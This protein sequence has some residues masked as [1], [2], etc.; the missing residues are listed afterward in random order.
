MSKIEPELKNI[1]PI[2]QLALLYKQSFVAFAATVAVLIYILFWIYDLVD[3]YSL[4]LWTGAIVALNIYLLTWVYFVRRATINTRIS[5]KKAKRFIL[6]YQVQ[7]VLHGSA[8]GALPFLLIELTSP[9]MKFFS[10]IILCGMAAGAIGTTAMIYHIYLSFMLPMMLPVI[11]TQLFL[12]N[13]FIFFSR[14]ILEMLII[15]VISLLVL[16]H[17]HFE[18]IKRS[19]ALMVENSKLLNDITKSYVKTQAASQAKRYFSCKH[20]SRVTHTIKYNFGL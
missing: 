5:S 9:E 18:S 14:N 6:I 7:A 11:L 12:H 13:N 16:A 10:Y 4:S 3:V 1:L 19:I 17:S 8:W 2:E 20:E 15:F